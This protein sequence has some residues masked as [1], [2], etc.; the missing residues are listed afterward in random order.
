MNKH[1]IVAAATVALNL[2][3]SIQPALA[4]QYDGKLPMYPRGAMAHGMESIPAGA[5]AQGVPYQQT[6][7]DSVH[8]V[9][10]WYKSNAPKSCTRQAESGAVQ[11]RCPGGSIVIQTHGST[12]I[13]FVPAFPHF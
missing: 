13:S 10:L 9:D 2:G 8:L 12:L 5:L 7:S 3:L 4:V 11:Y 6:T 1:L